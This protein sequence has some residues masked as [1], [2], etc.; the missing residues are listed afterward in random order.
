M[1]GVA[2]PYSTPIVSS[3]ATRRSTSHLESTTST[4]PCRCWDA[5]DCPIGTINEMGAASLQV[6]HFSSRGIPRISSWCSN[7]EIGIGSRIIVFEKIIKNLGFT[8]SGTHG[9]GA[10]SG[11]LFHGHARDRGYLGGSHAD[12]C[13][14][15][16]EK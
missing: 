7:V 3:N 1:K 14:K 6:S 9:C 5:A 15:S 8:V 2:I 12:G 11:A 4:P 16:G 10:A 13:S